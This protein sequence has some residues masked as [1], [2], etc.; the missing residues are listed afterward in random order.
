MDGDGCHFW[1]IF[2]CEFISIVKNAIEFRKYARTQ[3]LLGTYAHFYMK[4][5]HFLKVAVDGCHF[6]VIFY[7]EF[8]PIVEEEGSR[9]VEEG[10]RGVREGSRA[11]REGSR[12]VREGSRGVREGSRGVREASSLLPI[13]SISS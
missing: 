10:S 13:H 8:I 4:L 2:S 6:W 9:G 7:G 1:I 3:A 12:G 5:T 11:V